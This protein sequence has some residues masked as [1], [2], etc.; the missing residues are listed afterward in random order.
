M[1]KFYMAPPPARASQPFDAEASMDEESDLTATIV[2]DLMRS[3]EERYCVYSNMTVFVG[4]YNVNGQAPV[5][6]LSPWLAYGL[7]EP[8]DMY[9]LGFQ[10]L[11]LS[12]QAFLFDS[13]AREAEWAEVVKHALHP[14]EHYVEVSK[15]YSKQSILV[16][17]AE[18][19]THMTMG[20]VQLSDLC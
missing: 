5:V 13:T 17:N 14:K 3:W 6:N 7:E 20:F 19:N 18:C 1:A 9:V 10:E 11:D 2:E 16:N 12:Q 15:N 4:T 8:P